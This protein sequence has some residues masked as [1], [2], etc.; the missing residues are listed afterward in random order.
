M[1]MNVLNLGFVPQK[2]GILS[3][4]GCFLPQT[5]RSVIAKH[6]RNIFKDGELSG[7]S[8]CAEFAHTT[9]DGKVC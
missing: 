3:L 4:H 2:G 7:D 5:H 6:T 9:S 1:G 8:V